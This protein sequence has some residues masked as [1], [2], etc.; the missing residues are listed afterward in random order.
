MQ[1]W[2]GIRN[3]DG[4]Y[5][6]LSI[7]LVF[8]IA[9]FV[10]YLLKG[11]RRIEVWGV[12]WLAVMAVFS[13]F[14]EPAVPVMD[15]HNL[16]VFGN[17]FFAGIIFYRLKTYGKTFFRYL[18]LALC[19]A[20]QM[21]VKVHIHSGYIADPLLTTS[22]ILVF[23]GVFH[24]A[25]FGQL[26]FI[27]VRPMVFLGTISYALYLTHSHLSLILIRY[28]VVNEINVFFIFFIP[29]VCSLILATLVTFV[30]EKPAMYAIRAFY[31]SLRKHQAN[32]KPLAGVKEPVNHV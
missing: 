3:I 4:V 6:T 15:I 2:F 25:I 32:P 20:V 5:W 27:A 10:L 12:M 19:L 22:I 29:L 17:L 18:C 8:Y 16:L 13:R 30:I 24:M 1:G 26:K 28:M 31:Q 7:E 9:M 14:D 23:F 11:F 21:M